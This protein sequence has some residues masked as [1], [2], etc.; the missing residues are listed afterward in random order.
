MQ[1]MIVNMK[2][3]FGSCCYTYQAY[4]QGGTGL[5]NHFCFGKYSVRKKEEDN[6]DPFQNRFLCLFV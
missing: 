4:N 6:G 3:D 5:E 2:I 1:N